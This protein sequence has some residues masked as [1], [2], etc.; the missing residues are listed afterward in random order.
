ML[1]M[2]LRMASMLLR[3]ARILWALT[4]ILLR[5]II[6]VILIAQFHIVSG[7]VSADRAVIPIIMDDVPAV[8]AVAFVNRHDGRLRGMGC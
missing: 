6:E 4:R 7:W 3:I 5:L 1:V 8:A 2:L